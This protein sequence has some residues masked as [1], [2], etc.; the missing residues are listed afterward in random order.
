V[1]FVVEILAYYN[2]GY[3]P[4]LDSTIKILRTFITLQ[5]FFKLFFFL[6][7][8]KGFSFLVSM[9]LC[10]FND[11]QYFLGLYFVIIFMFA[12]VFSV[13]SDMVAPATYA[14]L[15]DFGFILDTLQLSLGAWY[16]DNY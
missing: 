6:R 10:V 12:I 7:I 3:F 15:G 11:L 8:F 14:G 4:D 16:V 2:V 13:L 1:L 9:L 5:A